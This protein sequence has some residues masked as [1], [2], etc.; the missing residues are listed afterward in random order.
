MIPAAR[1][2]TYP[3]HLARIAEIV[4]ESDQTRTFAL[5]LDPP[6]AAFDAARP[7]QFAMLSILGHGEAAFTLSTL[8]RAGG[9]HG[10]V[11]LTIRRMGRLTAALFELP[12]GAR[13]GLRGPFGRGFPVDD[14]GVPTVYVAGGCGL[15]PLKA[16]I[17]SQIAARPAGTPVAVI[18]GARDPESR[19]LT[20][21][22]SGWER[23]PEVRVIQCVEH[24]DLRWPGR[25]G[26]IIDF[27]DEAVTASV[28]RRA[29]VCGPPA[30]LGHA[31]RRLVSLGLRPEEIHVAMERT[32]ACG[33]GHCGRCYINQRYVCTD[34]PVFTLA[35]L[36]RLPEA[37]DPA[38]PF[39][40]TCA[41]HSEP[42][43]V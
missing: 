28:S 16:A 22:L 18:Y 35:E 27:I 37:F 5:T 42:V 19:I 9:A 38:A 30:M 3:P 14:P 26:R 13:V 43:R 2:G 11:T 6:S 25:R 34:G 15:A 7:G 24:A 39:Q 1:P 8:P 32:M 17:D 29:A 12:L 31:T 21:A 20:R 10:T 33:T 41:S 36:S 23:E 4:P 40:G